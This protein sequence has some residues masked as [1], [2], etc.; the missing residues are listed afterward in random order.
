MCL[1]FHKPADVTFNDSQLADMWAS[2]RDGF[3]VMYA[4][5]NTLFIDKAVGGVKDW[6]EFFRKYES[7]EA[8]FHLRMRTHGDIDLEN[9]H[10][11]IVWGFTKEESGKK[12]PVAMMHNGVLST[13]NKADTTKSDTWHFIRNYIKPLSENDQ[14]VIFKP[15]F[16]LLVEDFIGSSNKFA[17]MDCYGNLQIMNKDAGIEW[18]GVWF[19][20]TYAWSARSESLYP[21]INKC[22]KY[23]YGGYS[24]NNTW[25]SGSSASNYAKSST[26][27]TAYERDDDAAYEEYWAGFKEAQKN[28]KDDVIKTTKDVVEGQVVPI[29]P[30]AKTARNRQLPKKTKAR[31]GKTRTHNIGKWQEEAKRTGKKANPFVPSADST[32]EAEPE[33]KVAQP[34]RADVHQLRQMLNV[35]SNSPN[36]WPSSSITDKMLEDNVSK[37][38]A[39]VVASV[40]LAYDDGLIFG[41][42]LI[43]AMTNYDRMQELARM[44][45][46]AGYTDY[47]EKEKVDEGN[48]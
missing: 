36:A 46:D 42:D 20:N 41:I 48:S 27:S 30:P 7:E 16:R 21:G 19:S 29:S 17:I 38:G 24:G 31:S 28:N 47:E 40:L 12:T 2:N 43:E 5:D 22:H 39:D 6:I 23:S 14:A 10:P 37:F 45:S 11:Y 13:G 1:L 35:M 26:A 25:Y 3:G 44:T 4:K 8:C 32:D 18:N 33:H 34:Y 15:Q 9:T